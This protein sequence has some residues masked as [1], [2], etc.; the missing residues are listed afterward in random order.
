MGIDHFADT[1]FPGQYQCSP[2]AAQQV[3]CLKAVLSAYLHSLALVFLTLPSLVYIISISRLT[4]R[5]Q[6]RICLLFG[7]NRTNKRLKLLL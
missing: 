2:Q 5:H 3:Q 4:L 6:R 1:H 7:H